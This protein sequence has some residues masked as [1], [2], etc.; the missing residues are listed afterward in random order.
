LTV[1]GAASAAKTLILN[2]W[3]VPDVELDQERSRKSQIFSLL[4]ASAG[5][6]LV[7]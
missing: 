3:Q 6:N 2:C 1:S 5:L 7:P 4:A